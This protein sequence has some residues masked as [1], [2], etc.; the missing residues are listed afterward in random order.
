MGADPLK[1][2]KEGVGLP[3]FFYSQKGR[4]VMRKIPSYFLMKSDEKSCLIT[5]TKITMVDLSKK[6]P[7]LGIFCLKRKKVFHI[8]GF[9]RVGI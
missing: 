2:G 4:K 1:R 6:Y 3:F 7:Q 5:L 8:F 9:N